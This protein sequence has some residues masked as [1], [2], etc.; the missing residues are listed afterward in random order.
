MN[1]FSSEDFKSTLYLAH[2]PTPCSPERQVKEIYK[3]GKKNLAWGMLSSPFWLSALQM[4]SVL[5]LSV[6]P[7]YHLV[8]FSLL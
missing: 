2:L 1:D 5:M 3:V 4:P 6:I 8:F 7:A